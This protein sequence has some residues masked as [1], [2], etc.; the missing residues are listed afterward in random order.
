MSHKLEKDEE[1]N[2]QG[3]ERLSPDSVKF[4]ELVFAHGVSQLDWK[5]IHNANFVCKNWTKYVNG[6]F[7]LNPTYRKRF[8]E[9][10]PGED[11]KIVAFHQKRAD[12]DQNESTRCLLLILEG[13]MLLVFFLFYFLI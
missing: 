1:V 12:E 5:D 13:Q 10:F 7:V 4:S 9:A 6:P 8:Y 11:E 2:I 3:V